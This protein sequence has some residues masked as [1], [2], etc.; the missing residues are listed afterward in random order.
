MLTKIL[1]HLLGAVIFIINFLHKKYLFCIFIL[2]AHLLLSFT[3][4][5]WDSW[6]K[7]RKFS[8]VALWIGALAAFYALGSF[9]QNH[10]YNSLT[11]HNQKII[12]QLM[13]NNF[14]MPNKLRWFN[15]LKY[16]HRTSFIAD[17]DTMLSDKEKMYNDFLDYIK[18]RYFMEQW[19]EAFKLD[20]KMRG[21]PR[22]LLG[23]SFYKFRKYLINKSIDVNG[24]KYDKFSIFAVKLFHA[25]LVF[26]YQEGKYD[27]I[28]SLTAS[29]GLRAMMD[30]TTKFFRL[31]SVKDAKD[32]THTLNAY[33]HH[34]GD[35]AKIALHIDPKKLLDQRNNK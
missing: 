22:N 32:L 26:L 2:V 29:G 14:Q 6:S 9:L 11:A 5:R 7:T 16:F 24:N 25:K 21:H 1:L 18:L 30:P 33:R 3:I 13:K 8:V 15:N 19:P 10:N 35:I 23:S 31:L 12:H 17:D 27:E 28:R 20:F 4:N 34:G